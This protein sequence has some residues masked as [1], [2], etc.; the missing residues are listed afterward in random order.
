[1]SEITAKRYAA[2]GSEQ[3]STPLPEELFSQP[4]HEHLLWL[5]IKRY[6]GNQRATIASPWRSSRGVSA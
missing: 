2:D 6:L 1:M 3:G 4:V 5:S